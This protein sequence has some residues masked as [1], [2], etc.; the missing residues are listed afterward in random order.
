[1]ADV[2]RLKQMVE[3][4][5]QRARERQEAEDRRSAENFQAWTETTLSL[6]MREAL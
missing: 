3:E 5:R 6:A 2:E 1:M 4:V